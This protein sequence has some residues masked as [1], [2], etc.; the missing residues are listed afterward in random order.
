M[1]GDDLVELLGGG[2]GA[3]AVDDLA[4]GADEEFGE[5]PLDELGVEDARGGLF[6]LFEEGVGVVAVDLDALVHGEGDAVVF[7]AEG[8]DFVVGAGVLAAELVAGKAED[9][10]VLVVI[11]LP[12]V[13][14]AVELRGEAAFAGGVDDEEQFAAVVLEGGLLAVD[15]GDLGGVVDGGGV[16]GGH[17]VFLLRS[18]G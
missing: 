18:E 9:G 14:Q 8:G 2:A 6:E 16:G 11:F 7:A 3:E 17:G 1:L 5:V 10:E 13:F 12:E 15:G 4:V